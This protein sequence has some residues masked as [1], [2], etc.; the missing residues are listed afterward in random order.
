[1]RFFHRSNDDS[2][3]DENLPCGNRLLMIPI[4]TEPQRGISHCHVRL[5]VHPPD[6][7]WNPRHVGK[8]RTSSRNQT[9]ISVQLKCPN[10]TCITVYHISYIAYRCSVLEEWW[11][12]FEHCVNLVFF[13]VLYSYLIYTTYLIISSLA[14]FFWEPANKNPYLLCSFTTAWGLPRS[15]RSWPR[16]G[17]SASQTDPRPVGSFF[18]R[19]NDEKMGSWWP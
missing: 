5:P 8:R 6:A 2:L 12:M 18:F 9:W 15:S 17:S 19:G 7:P 1:M 3:V 11:F 13:N 16:R 10:Y 14:I 4:W